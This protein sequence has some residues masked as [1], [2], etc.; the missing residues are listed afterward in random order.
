MVPKLYFA[1][2]LYFVLGFVAGVIFTLF[3]GG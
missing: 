2:F 1:L 3:V